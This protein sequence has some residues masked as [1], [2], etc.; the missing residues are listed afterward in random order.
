MPL[1]RRKRDRSTAL[2]NEAQS[3]LEE[4]RVLGDSGVLSKGG[5]GDVAIHVLERS[6]VEDVV[7]FSAELELRAGVMA[8]GEVFVDIPVEIG[9]AVQ[10]VPIAAEASEVAEQRLRKTP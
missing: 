9:F 5:A 2:E 3:H 6:V 7:E 10:A 8:Q 1:S 4:P